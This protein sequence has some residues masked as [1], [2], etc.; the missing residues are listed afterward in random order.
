MIAYVL[1]LILWDSLT[2]GGAPTPKLRRVP[3][4]KESTITAPCPVDAKK[5]KLHCP[6]GGQR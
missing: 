3:V 4:V 5:Q 2:F 6:E 1:M